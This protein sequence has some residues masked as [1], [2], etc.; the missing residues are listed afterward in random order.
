MTVVINDGGREGADKEVWD[1][2]PEVGD[3]VESGN[4]VLVLS[5]LF[6]GDANPA[7]GDAARFAYMMNA[8]GAPPLGLEAAQL[9]G[10]VHWAQQHWQPS[11]VAL[12]S[13][14][15]R[16]QVVSLVA[17]ALEPKLFGKIAIHQGMHSLSYILDRAISSGRVPDMFCRDLYRDFDLNMLKAM[18]EPAAVSE[19]DYL[20]SAHSMQ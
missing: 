16:M 17:G 8:V 10:I 1:R 11:R 19:S 18:A 5:L 14:G 12:E 4:Q 9:I 13:S 15:Y 20:E 6:T 7:G 3:A 2:Y